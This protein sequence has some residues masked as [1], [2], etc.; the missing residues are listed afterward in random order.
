M[1]LKIARRMAVLEQPERAA[2]EPASDGES[3]RAC[4]VRKERCRSLR[5]PHQRGASCTVAHSSIRG[6]AM[7]SGKQTDHVAGAARPATGEARE[8]LLPDKDGLEGG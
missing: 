2:R 1:S 4:R 3:S 8:G 6:Q 7:I 5:V